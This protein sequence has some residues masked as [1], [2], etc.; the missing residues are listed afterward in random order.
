MNNHDRELEE[1]INNPNDFPIEA[2][3]NN[4][5][6]LSEQQLLAE[7]RQNEHSRNEDWQNWFYRHFKYIFSGLCLIFGLILLILVWHWVAPINCQWLDATQLDN[8]KNIL[9]AVFASN[10]VGQWMNKIK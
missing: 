3:D 1:L 10:A 8:L 6:G 4:S 2:P 9:L 7:S 5:H